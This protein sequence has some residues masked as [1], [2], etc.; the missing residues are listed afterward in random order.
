MKVYAALIFSLLFAGNFLFAQRPDWVNGYADGCTSVTLGKK[1]TVDG[2]VITS[3]TDDSHRTRSWMDVVP[4]KKHQ[5]NSSTTMYKRVA[6]DSFAMPTYAHIPIGEIPQVRETYQFLNTAYPCMN[7]YQVGIGEST[8]GGREELQSDSGLIDCQRLCRLM[9]ERCQ[10]ARE[11][12][13]LAGRLTA[14]YGWNDFGECLT[15]ADKNEVWHLEILGPGK[16]K[17]GSV[18]AAQRVPDDHVAV[19]ANASTIKEIDLEDRDHFM[20]SA[21]IYEVA[22]KAGWWKEGDPFLFCYAYAPE[23]G[24]RWRPGEENGGCLIC[25]RHPCT[26]IPT[27]KIIRFQ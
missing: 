7:Q 12:I 18:W 16:G 2:S 17:V 20:A 21:N 27:R 15:I 13:E 4:A 10:T 23:S 19:N 26:W 5:Q 11:A 9:L 24:P 8:F 6:C 14:A 22:E 1:A 25:W 3:H